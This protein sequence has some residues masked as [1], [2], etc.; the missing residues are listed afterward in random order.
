MRKHRKSHRL[1]SFLLI[2][3]LC[4]SLYGCGTTDPEEIKEYGT[5]P[6]ESQ[7]TEASPVE[8]IEETDRKTTAR[9]LHEI[10]GDPINFQTDFFTDSTEV[11]ADIS[12][13]LP[14][15]VNYLNIYDLSRSRDWWYDDKSYADGF[16]DGDASKV[17]SFDYASETKYISLM[18]KYRDLVNILEQNPTD[19]SIIKPDTDMTFGWVDNDDY[20]I[21]LYEGTYNGTPYGLILAHDENEA[22]SYIYFEPLDIDEYFPGC[23][24]TTLMLEQAEA[25]YMEPLENKCTMDK[26]ELFDTASEFL[27]ERVGLSEEENRLTLDFDPYLSEFDDYYFYA[28]FTTVEHN[29]LTALSFSDSDFISTLH[30]CKFDFRGIDILRDQPD[31]LKEYTETHDE[32]HPS[33]NFYKARSLVEYDKGANITT[34]GYAV[35]LRSQFQVDDTSDDRLYKKL[36][37]EN[38]GIIKITSRGIYGVDL[39]LTGQIKG[40]TENID[41]LELDELKEPFKNG[42]EDQSYLNNN[43][44]EVHVDNMLI[45]YLPVEDKEHPEHITMIPVWRFQMTAYDSSDAACFYDDILI[46]AIDGSSIE[47][48][49]KYINN[50]QTLYDD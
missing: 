30:H 23:N 36:R 26:D 21:H 14:E 24:Y 49:E 31:Q 10:Y 48:T 35:F 29:D 7:T 47:E 19:G 43:T 41:L 33:N 25:P 44:K 1:I 45:D 38:S 11:I 39:K 46:N 6:E 34:D 8:K 18:H 50:F 15:N 22:V 42:F 37:Y 5:L 27:S 32:I 12:K 9:S 20:S 17:V 16:F 13:P 2:G 4:V 3:S 28:A 40:V